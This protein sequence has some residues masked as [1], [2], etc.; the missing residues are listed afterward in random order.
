MKSQSDELVD[1]YAKCAELESVKLQLQSEADKVSAR[2]ADVARLKGEVAD[3]QYDMAA[4][5]LVGMA[6]FGFNFPPL[7]TS[8]LH[9]RAQILKQNSMLCSTS[10][11]P[12]EG[13]LQDV[14]WGGNR[15]LA[16]ISKT[17]ECK[18]LTAIRL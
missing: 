15:H 17:R 9:W 11:V 2:D 7:A 16:S 10:G 4:C 14:G 5:R 3:M 13:H 8:L 12:L 6:H 18:L 1:L